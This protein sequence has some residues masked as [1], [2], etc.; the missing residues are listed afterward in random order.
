MY[1]V[2]ESLFADQNMPLYLFFDG[3][4]EIPANTISLALSCF[5]KIRSFFKNACIYVSTR[6]ELL[7]QLESALCSLALNIDP[8]NEN[9]QIEFL[10]AHWS[11]G[12]VIQELP[13]NTDMLKEFANNSL[14][15]L[16]SSLSNDGKDI[17]GVPLQC[18]L[19]AEVLKMEAEEFADPENTRESKAAKP[20]LKISSMSQLY[21][22]VFQ[23]KFE[24][25]K[26]RYLEKDNR[27]LKIP[28]LEAVHLQIGIETIFPDVN[29]NNKLRP[30]LFS[31]NVY[32]DL[33]I[34]LPH[35]QATFKQF[36]SGDL[37]QE[38]ILRVGI[39]ESVGDGKW[40]LVHRT[41]G[42]Y[43][44]A[45]FTTRQISTEDTCDQDVL[46]F[47]TNTV[48]KS[49]V[50]D[51]TCSIIQQNQSC[52][53][54]RKFKYPVVC[55]FINSWLHHNDCSNFTKKFLG[56]GP[57]TSWES[58]VA[59][60]VRHNYSNMLEI[61]SNFVNFGSSDETKIFHLA[62]CYATEETF[63]KLKNSKPIHSI[64]NP[65]LLHVAVEVGNVALVSYLLSSC[66]FRKAIEESKL[67]P[68]HDLIPYCIA[69]TINASL[70]VVENRVKILQL[71]LK[72]KGIHLSL[73]DKYGKTPMFQP[74]VHVTLLCQMVEHMTPNYLRNEKDEDDR[75]IL[76]RHA[77][78][79]K[80]NDF[81][82]FLRCLKKNK[83]DEALSLVKYRDWCG[84]TPL[85]YLVS[86]MEPTPEIFE[87][88][89]EINTDFYSRN[90]TGYNVLWCL[91]QHCRNIDM[92]EYMLKKD[93]HIG[94]TEDMFK[95]TSLHIAARHLKN[96]N[97]IKL[98]ISQGCDVNKQDKFGNTPLFYA[99][100]NPD[101]EISK[102]CIEILQDHKADLHHRNQNGESLFHVAAQHGNVSAMELLF[103]LNYF[104]G[105]KYQ[106]RQVYSIF[107]LVD[108]KGNTPLHHALVCSKRTTISTIQFLV[109]RFLS[110][111]NHRNERGYCPL[112]HG[113]QRK[114][115]YIK[116]EVIEYLERF[117][118]NWPEQLIT[119]SIRALSSAKVLDK[120]SKERRDDL[121]KRI[122]GKENKW[123]KSL[124]LNFKM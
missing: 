67:Q 108:K 31:T 69:N 88:F 25:F 52:T 13:V 8:F 12:R 72:C 19:I 76:H 121:I 9:N 96:T 6:P 16:R 38:D 84:Q 34:M 40:Q 66:G 32:H 68:A 48:L 55:H 117:I 56:I 118:H 2:P 44:V 70:K 122:S 107:S 15:T 112:Q 54:N 75:T 119:N 50:D 94:V 4:D 111:V 3:L 64:S 92:I 115:D 63:E 79:L 113:L 99:L 101:H 49:D 17:A 87:T 110:D 58:I 82:K 90:L 22:L 95:R 28:C 86:K 35:W 89:Q 83:P 42:E 27:P 21:E 24:A 46:D 81:N 18:L 74:R 1:D 26:I 45:M 71:L 93:R 10:I 102:R 73:K 106:N 109:S 65:S 23:R 36:Q 98:L 11:Y 80:P 14:D 104:G 53:F 78:G 62:A 85:H 91:F 5:E 100:R 51:V 61:F 77:D 41:F 123:G 29:S 20:S 37:P 33:K 124:R 60:C 43:L 105:N 97:V 7:S 47:I 116:F 30:K 59:A 103:Q 120:S 114:K 57:S 39:V